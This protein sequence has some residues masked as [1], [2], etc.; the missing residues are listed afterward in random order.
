MLGGYIGY[1]ITASFHVLSA[2]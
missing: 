2:L 1:A